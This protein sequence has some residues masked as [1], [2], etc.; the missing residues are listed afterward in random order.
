MVQIEA[1]LLAISE[2]SLQYVLVPLSFEG[3]A[4]RLILANPCICSGIFAL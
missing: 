1:L 3:N 4:K 2:A